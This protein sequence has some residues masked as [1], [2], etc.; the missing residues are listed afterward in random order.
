MKSKSATL[1][2]VFH[3]LL[4][5]HDPEEIQMLL[6]RIHAINAQLTFGQRKGVYDT[7]LREAREQAIHDVQ[8]QTLNDKAQAILDEV[9]GMSGKIYALVPVPCEKAE[10]LRDCLQD[11]VQRLAREENPLM[12]H[13]I[14]QA[15]MR[16]L[17]DL[18][19]KN[20][21][22]LGY[23]MFHEN[24]EA[25]VLGAAI[26]QEETPV[27]VSLYSE[28]NFAPIP[29]LA[30]SMLHYSNSDSNYWTTGGGELAKSESK[31]DLAREIQA[32]QDILHFAT[33]A[34]ATEYNN[35]VR[36]GV[37][38]RLLMWINEAGLEAKHPDITAC[39]NSILNINFRRPHLSGKPVP[40]YRAAN[41]I[42]TTY[43]LAAE[44][45]MEMYRSISESQGDRMDM[46]PCLYGPLSEFSV[47]SMV[48]RLY[49]ALEEVGATMPPVV[50]ALFRLYLA[51]GM[52]TSAL[53]DDNI[54]KW[55]LGVQA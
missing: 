36:E 9:K 2:K 33:A 55:V 3:R 6:N 43:S 29:S 52:S 20:L 25:R 18:P 48:I 32:Y 54:C 30:L 16:W 39:V 15:T 10:S 27:S 45:D 5:T 7:A 24:L 19:D 13:Q 4:D 14:I 37:V 34:E 42:Y 46:C 53:A 17:D 1:I 47:F 26:L 11:Y 50:E 8:T 12:V 28:L 23:Y 40:T 35:Q 22:N 38:Y 31:A 44:E 51:L 41:V 49:Q 21:R